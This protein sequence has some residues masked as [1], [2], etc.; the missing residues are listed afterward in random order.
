M[1]LR[2]SYR[3]TMLGLTGPESV[4]ALSHMEKF[5]AGGA[6]WTQGT[7]NRQDGAKCLVGAA[8]HVQRT[9]GLKLADPKYWLRRA[10]AEREGS[11]G[12]IMGIETFNDSR[13]SYSE[14][15]PVLSRAK[16]L[17]SEYQTQQTPTRPALTY[18]P[19]EDDPVVTITLT[20]MER[21]AVKHRG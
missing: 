8:N 16:Q 12:P 20:D 11:V 21:V 1:G 5:F 6:R 2:D 17:A 9:T 19:R 18:R 15:A 13:T 10:I 3:K 14:I 4:T 7:Y